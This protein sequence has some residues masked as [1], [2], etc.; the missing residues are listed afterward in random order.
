MNAV[1]IALALIFGI[2]LAFF[3]A[4]PSSADTAAKSPC[5]SD[6]LSKFRQG[7]FVDV[8]A[9]CTAVIAQHPDDADAYLMRSRAYYFGGK[10]DAALADVDKALDLAPKNPYNW[11]FRCQVK[12]QMRMFYAALNDCNHALEIDPGIPEAYWA[13]GTLYLNEHSFAKAVDDFS[14]YLNSN[15]NDADAHYNRAIAYENLGDCKS[16]IPDF[17]AQQR[18]QGAEPDGL[19]HRSECELKIG[20]TDAGKIDLVKAFVIYKRSGN[21][22]GVDAATTLMLKYGIT[23]SASP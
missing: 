19:L 15:A 8:A 13:R 7:D 6:D 18:L 20:Q 16:A 10:L 1:R 2:I 21:S 14:T 9:D 23:A 22:A 17:T 3:A 5:L 12:K 11:T 4:A